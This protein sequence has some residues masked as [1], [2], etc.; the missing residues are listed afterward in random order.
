MM[1]ESKIRLGKG[2]HMIMGLVEVVQGIMK[3]LTL[4]WFRPG[5]AIRFARWRYLSAKR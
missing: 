3:F 2:E 1:P 5:W 4:G